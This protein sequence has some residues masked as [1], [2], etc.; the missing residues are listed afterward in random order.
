MSGGLK[1]QRVAYAEGNLALAAHMLDVD[2]PIV[3]FS[4]CP[5][6]PP[7]GVGKCTELPDNDGIQAEEW[8]ER[9]PFE[10]VPNWLNTLPGEGNK[11]K[12]VIVYFENATTSA[13][14]QGLAQAATLPNGYEGA[15]FGPALQVQRKPFFSFWD[16]P[17]SGTALP[18]GA[19]TFPGEYLVQDLF[20]T[21]HFDN[22]RV[23]TRGVLQT[24]M[25][26][27]AGLTR[28]LA[29]TNALNPNGARDTYMQT[30]PALE[31][32]A[33][34]LGGATGFYSV[35]GATVIK[36]FLQDAMKLHEDAPSPDAFCLA[37]YYIETWN[38]AE[39]YR[40][41]MALQLIKELLKAKD[42]KF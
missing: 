13:N 14:I 9:K 16:I 15:S 24:V 20:Q 22:Y 17:G 39:D 26:A 2:K 38:L 3:I 32:P 4:F 25:P 23:G 35:D 40:N 33:Q 27:H 19:A 30:P 36:D 11:G 21:G 28:M 6:K 8:L 5:Q 7:L 18:Q 37:K 34:P 42:W 29:V 12:V 1:L 10:S 41:D 31:Q